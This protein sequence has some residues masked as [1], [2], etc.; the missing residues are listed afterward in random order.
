MRINPYIAE[1]TLACRG[2]LVCPPDDL[3]GATRPMQM[4]AVMHIPPLPTLARSGCDGSP[5]CL[6]PI[7]TKPPIFGGK[8]TPLPERLLRRFALQRSSLGSAVRCH[9]TTMMR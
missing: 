6:P 7:I 9:A 1:K 2:G 5:L 8:A 4:E 3:V